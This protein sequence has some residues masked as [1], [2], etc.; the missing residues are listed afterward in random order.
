MTL[1]LIYAVGYFFSWSIDMIKE[2]VPDT[3]K[4]VMISAGLC[5]IWPV[6]WVCALWLVIKRIVAK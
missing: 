1:L 4:A 2:P 5:T 3:P 6:L